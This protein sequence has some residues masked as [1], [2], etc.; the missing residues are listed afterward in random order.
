MMVVCVELASFEASS[1]VSG[2]TLPVTGGTGSC[3]EPMG[4]CG[5]AA[6][7]GCGCCALDSR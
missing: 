1:R 6:G 2:G 3:F 5:T 7:I 4:V